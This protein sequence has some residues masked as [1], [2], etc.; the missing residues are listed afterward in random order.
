MKSRP[1]NK[2]TKRCKEKEEE[3]KGYVR[4]VTSRWTVNYE[5]ESGCPR[6]ASRLDVTIT[7]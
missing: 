4:T 2:T 6:L 5:M 1:F 3:G 7:G